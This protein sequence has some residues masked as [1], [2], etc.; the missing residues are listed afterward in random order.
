MLKPQIE[1]N[2]EPCPDFCNE[3]IINGDDMCNGQNNSR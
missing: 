1:N 2:H 3:G